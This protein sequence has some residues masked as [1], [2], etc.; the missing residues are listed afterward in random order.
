MVHGDSSEEAYV[1]SFYP[2]DWLLAE[3]MIIMATISKTGIKNFWLSFQEKQKKPGN[4]TANISYERNL[5]SIS[6]P[7]LINRVVSNQDTV[8]W[9]FVSE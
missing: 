5:W 6:V 9:W 1:C 2:A 4:A 7:I 3:N 8:F